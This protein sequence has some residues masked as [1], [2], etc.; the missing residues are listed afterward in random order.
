MMRITSVRPAGRA[1]HR[2]LGKNLPRIRLELG[3]MAR[4]KA[5]MPMVKAV[6]MAIW[7]GAKG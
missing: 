4:T 3:S 7:E 6:V 5:G 1:R 2:T